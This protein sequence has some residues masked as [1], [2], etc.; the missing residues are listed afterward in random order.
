ML[1]FSGNIAP[2][3][4]AVRTRLAALAIGMA[5]GFMAL[6]AA[7]TAQSLPSGD[8]QFDVNYRRVS[9]VIRPARGQSADK[10]RVTFSLLGAERI[11]VTCDEDTGFQY[12]PEQTTSALICHHPRAKY[13]VAR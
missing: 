12:H 7:G 9:N 13:F 2:F 6:P 4:S 10:I 8:L 3:R 5:A 1:P 11:G